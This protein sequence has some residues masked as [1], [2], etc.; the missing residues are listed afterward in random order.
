MLEFQRQLVFKD[1]QTLTE[2]D[3]MF[4]SNR[5]EDMDISRG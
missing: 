2:V 5:V 1:D 4:K 3:I